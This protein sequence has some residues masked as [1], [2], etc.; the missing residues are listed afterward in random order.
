M[1]LAPA[2]IDTFGDAFLQGTSFEQSHCAGWTFQVGWERSQTVSSLT[3]FWPLNRKG[4]EWPLRFHAMG[5][6][7][8]LVFTGQ[9]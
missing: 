4:W 8:L 3:E 6:D 9:G 5:V 2:L 7:L 1:W